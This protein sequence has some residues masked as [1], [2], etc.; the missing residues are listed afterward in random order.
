VPGLLAV[1]LLI[2]V[3]VL[4]AAPAAAV[5]RGNDVS[6]P[7]CPGG[8]PMPPEDTS[9]VVV[10]LT[11][12][13]AFTENPCLAEQVQWVRD[14]RVRAQAYTVATFPTPAQYATHGGDGPWPSA[15]RPDRLRNVGYAEGR[16]ALA[17]LDGVGWHPERVWVDV[18]PRPRQPWPTSTAT[19]RQENRYVVTGILTALTDAGLRDGIYSYSRAWRDITGSWRLPSLPVWSAAGRLDFP[20]EASD[21]CVHRGFSG[22]TVHLAQ[23]TDGTYDHDM[24]CADVYDA[25]VATLGW[26]PSVADGATA[27]TTG[28]ALSLEALRLSVAGGRWSGDVLWRGHVQRI[29]WQPWMTSASAIGT[30]GRGLRLEAF[31][32]RLTG[33]LAAHYGVRYRAHVQRVG[34]QSWRADGALAGTVGRGLRMEAVRVELVPKAAAAAATGAAQALHRG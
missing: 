23:W 18:E 3:A 34:W 14:H 2:A 12:G 26:L 30:T 5:D 15:T 7:Q 29:G 16:A 13:L 9:F 10:G 27:G 11:H 32:L 24:T 8:L 33:A 20:S 28:R 21:L 19:Q 4:F 22:G 25:H 6:W 1:L 31:E 17:S